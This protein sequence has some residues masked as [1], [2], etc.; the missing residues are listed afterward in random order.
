ML[1]FFVVVLIHLYFVSKEELRQFSAILT[2][3]LVNDAES[4]QERA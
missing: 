2:S 3:G 4:A 1:A